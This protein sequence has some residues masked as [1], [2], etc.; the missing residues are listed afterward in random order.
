M[1]LYGAC[2]SGFEVI[3]VGADVLGRIVSRNKHGFAHRIIKL[4][5]G[6]KKRS[7]SWSDH[8]ALGSRDL[9]AGFVRLFVGDRDEVIEKIAI[10]N[11]GEVLVRQSGDAFQARQAVVASGWLDTD[12]LDVRVLGTGQRH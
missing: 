12:D 1:H 4:S 5:R 8:D 2:E 6:V 7:G 10:E 9:D 11:F 3:R